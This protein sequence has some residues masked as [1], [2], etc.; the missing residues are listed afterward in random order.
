M[1]NQCSFCIL[2]RVVGINSPC[3]HEYKDKRKMITLATAMIAIC[4]LTNFPNLPSTVK[5]D[6]TLV[7]KNW[8]QIQISNKD[9]T[10]VIE[11]AVEKKKCK[12]EEK[13]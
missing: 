9:K 11:I 1:G 6:V 13:K 7:T 2:F 10:Q 5:G 12:L 3:T 8:V 4:T